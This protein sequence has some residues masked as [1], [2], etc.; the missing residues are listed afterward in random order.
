MFE[1]ELECDRCSADVTVEAEEE[2][3][4]ESVICGQCLL[5]ELVEG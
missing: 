3:P 4:A 2:P 5:E 1:F